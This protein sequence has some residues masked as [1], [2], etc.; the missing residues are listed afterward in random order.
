MKKIPLFFTKAI[1]LVFLTVP[2][3]SS[4]QSTTVNESA[5]RA[6]LLQLIAVL[7]QQIALLQQLQEQL[8]VQSRPVIVLGESGALSRKVDMVAVYPLSSPDDVASIQNKNHRAYFNRVLELFPDTYEEKLGRVAVYE[9]SFDFDAFVETLPPK[10]DY[11]L[12]AVNERM[13]E[14]V[15]TEWNTELIVHELAHIVSYDS[16]SGKTSL[17][18]QSCDA[19]FELHGC[20]PEGSYLSLFVDDFWSSSDL[21]RAEEFAE[22][23]DDYKSAYEYY[24]EHASNYVSD[25][26][27]VAPEED[28]AESFV[29]YMLDDIPSGRVARQK[30]DFFGQFSNLTKIRSKIREM[31]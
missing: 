11:W 14:D 16:L 12:Y 9:D 17:A 7:Q 30:V 23:N 5:Q 13:L 27:A 22:A 26:A 19:Y 6:L 31:K 4:A 18:N 3:M 8:A 21:V 1:L 20:P 24:N 15:T 10:H 2:L 28:F 29:Y 25:Y